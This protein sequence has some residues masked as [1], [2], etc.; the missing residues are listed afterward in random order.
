[1]KTAVVIGATGLV[2]SELI[3]KLAQEASHGQ[4]IAVCRG[5]ASKNK[6]NFN[7]PKV[8]VLNFDFKNW[9]DLELQVSSFLGTS[10]ANFFCCLGT[11]ISKAGNEEDFKKVDLD[12]VVNF[13]KLAK[14]CRAEQLLVVSALG[15]DKNSS[16]FYNRTKGEMEEAVKNEFGGKT[17]FFRPSLLLGD[18]KDFRFGER[19]AILLA[20]IY[21]PLLMG[22]LRKYQPVPASKVAQ[23]MVLV[24]AKKTEAPM[25]VENN[26]I[27]NKLDLKI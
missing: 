13:A 25:F 27:L 14:S 22:S 23:K 24:A 10:S 18:R 7:N 17:Y 1:M 6:P 12:Y 5:N 19:V 8:R 26:F 2:G 20:P 3:Q 9:N 15:A 21:T 4:I 16:V 11:T